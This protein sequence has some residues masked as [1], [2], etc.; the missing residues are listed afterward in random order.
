[1]KKYADQPILFAIGV[2]HKTASIEV[3]ERVYIH[4]YEIPEFHEKLGETLSECLVLSTC[5]RTEIY[6]VC[7]SSDI[8]LDFYKDLVINFKNAAGVVKRE[9]F[10]SFISC[11]AC[12]QLFKV[13]TSVDS[14]I[15]GDTQI[16]QQVRNAY[17]FAKENRSTG[18]ILNQLAQ[19]AIK[20][21]KKTYTETSIHKGAISISL[22]AV[23]SAIE[24]FG[25][26]KD[27]SV[28]IVGAG[29][30]ARL[31][32]ECLIKKQVG[33]IFITNRTRTKA[34]EL[35]SNLP[36]SNRLTGE[37]IEFSAFKSYL[38]RTDIVISSTSSTD[39][40]LDEKDFAGQS[41]KILLIDIA[42]PRDISPAVSRN[43]NV[44]LKNIDDLNS[45]VDRNF[46]KRMSDLP[47]VKK[48]IMKE[49]SDFL[50]WYYSLP[51]LPE[52]QKPKGKPDT[53][54]LEEIRQVKEFLAKNVS[55]FHKMARRAG[56]D[57]ASDLKNHLELVNIL[58]AA[59]DAAKKERRV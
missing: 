11:A 5:N 23:E 57:A 44:V 39:Y 19:R 56:D 9:N 28:L 47:K 31:T 49:M 40:I 43:R 3:R 15:I 51:L 38:N 8:D 41:N 32:A 29:D 48:I 52:F 34:E 50:T 53:E 36:K 27:K 16:L 2:N 42:V 45:I 26:I 54:A 30:T 7:D 12:Q 59:K 24:T 14:K 33:K 20:I 21:G 6:G 18:K 10:F 22:A 13:S 1:M 58:Y 55:L 46:E 17:A 25:S 4:E 37:V 35:L